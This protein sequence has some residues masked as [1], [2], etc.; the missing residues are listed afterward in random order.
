MFFLS[1]GTFAFGIDANK[2][3]K[4]DMESLPVDAPST[5]ITLSSNEPD[6]KNHSQ[7]KDNEKQS[8][9]TV[10]F[11]ILSEREVYNNE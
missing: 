4:N 5:T 9:K 2:P 1:L 3:I 11:T 10:I 6:D 7:T 8:G